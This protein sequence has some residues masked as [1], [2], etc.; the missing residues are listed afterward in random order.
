MSIFRRLALLSAALLFLAV[1]VLYGLAGASLPRTQG[2]AVV[3][4]RSAPLTI[5]RDARG[6]PTITAA[7][8]ADAWFG[9]GYVH[10]QDRLFQLDLHRR[11]AAGRLSEIVGA[12]AL[13]L[14]RAM[15]TL[16]L[17]RAADSSWAVL[18]PETRAALSAYAAGINAGQA[19]L[20]APP[21]EY[22]LLG[23]G[24]EP[25]RPTDSLLF[26]RLMALRLSG[27]WREEAR[28]AG[29]RDT[30]GD[31][32]FRALLAL[33]DDGDQRGASGT[34]AVPLPPRTEALGSHA[35][36]LA[37]AWPKEAAP[38]TASNW[39]LVDSARSD[40]GAL[41][42]N[43][44]HL[45][46]QA[47][48]QWYLATL[49]TPDGMVSG[50]T[51]PAIPFPLVGHNGAMAW[52]LTTTHSD[53]ADLVV[54]RALPEGRYATPSGPQPVETRTETIRVK[55]ADDVSLTVRE[56]RH[57]P[58]VGDLVD[59]PLADDR[60]V[61]LQAAALATGDRT[62]DA[63]L[64]L[65]RAASWAEVLAAVDRFDAPQQNIALAFRD[66]GIGF[67]SPGR[68]PIR[69]KGD[70]RLPRPGDDAAW[71]WRGWQPLAVLPQVHA[72]SEGILVNANNRPVPLPESA[73]LGADF[74]PAYR[75]D[76]IRDLLDGLVVRDIDAV[77]AIQQDSA[78]PPVD[79]LRP[80][81]AALTASPA[82]DLLL[83]WDGR[84][85]VDQGAP[86]LYAAFLAEAE[87]TIF[88]DDLG[89]AF[90]DWRGHRAREVIAA[91]SDGAAR[92]CSAIGCHVELESAL[93]S[94][95]SSLL[96]AFG[97]M[98]AWRW[99][100]VHRASLSHSLFRHV[101][102]LS[103][104]TDLSVPAPGGPYT[105]N[106]GGT[107]IASDR[108]WAGRL[109]DVHGPGLRFSIDMDRPEE[110]RA[111]IATGQSG[112]PLSPHYGDQTKPW[113]Q[114]CVRPLTE[115]P[116]AVLRLEPPRS[117]R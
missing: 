102:L 110:A 106:R 41:L 113:S 98:E 75:A 13:D 53:T 65:T 1:L 61:V 99:G 20:T 100:D 29:L 116:T 39:W 37:D 56:T 8:W 90:T 58:A 85:T 103:R 64:A 101:P 82:R 6:V 76:R 9:L 95:E 28:N 72:P 15:R 5:A 108:D 66:G 107:P 52:G 112:H 34:D 97:P 42:A 11:V 79:A 67:I 104:L 16:G 10:A 43:D 38:L 63:A 51:I 54:E 117:T 35:R 2:T 96:A 105:I 83:A 47:P 45:E 91:V 73:I 21:P 31:E 18:R 33:S 94:A 26:S 27:N 44:P 12:K 86:L 80:F 57:G 48:I 92:W 40:G 87:R 60:F 24:W 55:G 68:V 62:A 88:A 77:A 25:W 74:P 14:D 111:V 109:S 114:G 71:D 3:V 22:L 50:G 49:K 89:P 93:Q 36:R 32:A 59:P 23:V 81:L 17:G 4:G 46:L 30:I 70:G 19:S 69:G 84:M 115:S 78:S 7:S